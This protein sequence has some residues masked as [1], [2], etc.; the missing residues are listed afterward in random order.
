MF[1]KMHARETVKIFNT[2]YCNVFD[3]LQRFQSYYN[4]AIFTGER[5]IMIGHSSHVRCQNAAENGPGHTSV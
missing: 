2:F 1:L 5:L 3:N 4:M